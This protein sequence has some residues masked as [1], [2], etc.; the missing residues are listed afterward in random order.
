MNIPN[1]IVTVMSTPELRKVLGPINPNPDI[2]LT[3]K[4]LVETILDPSSPFKT[5]PLES[6]KEGVDCTVQD[7]WKL[8]AQFAKVSRRKSRSKSRS[9]SDPGCPREIPIGAVIGDGQ[10]EVPGQTVNEGNPFPSAIKLEP[11]L[12]LQDAL[13]IDDVKPTEPNITPPSASDPGPDSTTFIPTVKVEIEKQ[14]ADI[15]DVKEEVSP[16]V[17]L[18]K[19]KSAR[20]KVVSFAPS[21]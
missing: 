12:E 2:A 14:L 10:L 8:E 1:N 9:R 17:V 18:E 4:T 3:S 20:V 7:A 11:G 21:E 6:A 19:K 15:V 5:M 13:R 16:E